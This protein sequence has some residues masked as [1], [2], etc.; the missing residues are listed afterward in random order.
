M[1]LLV[2]RIADGTAAAV[3]LQGPAAG[4]D[5]TPSVARGMHQF[6]F[7]ASGAHQLRHDVVERRGELGLQQLGGLAPDRLLRPPAVELGRRAVPVG[8]DVIL[9][10]H[11]DRVV[12]EVEQARML[13]QR[14]DRALMARGKS[15][16]DGDRHQADEAA[17]DGAAGRDRAR[18]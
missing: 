10:A 5:E 8:D 15:A 2:S 9:V 13:A 17:Q 16:G 11:E 4:H 14:L 3:A 18:G 7:P 1:S 6:A 12:R